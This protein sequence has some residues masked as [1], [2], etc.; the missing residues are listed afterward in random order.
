MRKISHKFDTFTRSRQIEDSQDQTAR[1]AYG[2][3]TVTNIG[4]TLLHYYQLIIQL[5]I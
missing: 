3:S 5:V 1:N 4:L 2:M